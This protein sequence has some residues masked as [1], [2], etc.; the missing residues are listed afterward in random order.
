[1]HAVRRCPQSAQYAWCHA[2]VVVFGLFLTIH[3]YRFYLLG[4]RSS[5]LVSVA[6]ANLLYK[7][8]RAYLLR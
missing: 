7:M 5:E 3:A 8:I 6:A 2:A 1:M 4:S